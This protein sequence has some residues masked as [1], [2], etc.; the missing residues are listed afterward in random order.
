M[1]DKSTARRRPSDMAARMA[2]VIAAESETTSEP[3]QAPEPEAPKA[4]EPKPAK[5]AR[6]AAPAGA[7]KRGRQAAPMAAE[8]PK[9]Q[10]WPARVPFTTNAD[11]DRALKTARLEDGIQATARLRAMVAL[12]MEDERIRARVDKLARTFQ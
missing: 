8:Q 2:L 1:P 12:W 4:A 10:R 6:P 7:P 3:E 11:Q 5:A 9:G